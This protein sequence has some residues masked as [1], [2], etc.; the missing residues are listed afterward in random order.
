MSTPVRPFDRAIVNLPLGHRARGGGIDA[1]I[2]RAVRE[3][4]RDE[5]EAHSERLSAS[6]NQKKR[7]KE[8]LSRLSDERAMAL[9]KPLGCRKPET[10]RARLCGAFSA[11]LAQ[12]LAALERELAA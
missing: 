11:N 9:A 8:L 6:R 7:L 1:Q 12:S 3:I 4:R 2:D 5:A 10:A